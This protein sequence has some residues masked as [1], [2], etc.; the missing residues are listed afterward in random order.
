ML[1]TDVKP[2]FLFLQRKWGFSSKCCTEYGPGGSG[3]QPEGRKA[4]PSQSDKNNDLSHI[5]RPVPERLCKTLASSL[6]LGAPQNTN[7]I[8]LPTGPHS[9]SKSQLIKHG[10]A[11]YSGFF[12]FQFVFCDLV[13]RMWKSRITSIKIITALHGNE[14]QGMSVLT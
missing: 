11:N 5:P 2:M 6:G 8:S 13:Y 3:N 12:S 9:N 7:L 10:I 14:I 4:V 1:I